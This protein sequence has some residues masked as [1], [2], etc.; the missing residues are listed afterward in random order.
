M[1]CIN[2]QCAFAVR[3]V[4]TLTTEKARY[5]IVIDLVIG[6]YDTILQSYATEIAAHDDTA[7]TSVMANRGS[8]G[9]DII[10]NS[11][12]RYA[13]CAVQIQQKRLL[14]FQQSAIYMFAHFYSRYHY[15]LVNSTTP[16][17]HFKTFLNNFSE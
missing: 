9:W 10:P 3:K 12:L 15:I 11:R 1:Y 16:S 13:I 14:L 2:I 6:F 17:N 4:N 8:E 5:T 7:R